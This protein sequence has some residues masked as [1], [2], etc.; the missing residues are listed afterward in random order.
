[1]K[2]NYEI[3]FDCPK[4]FKEGACDSV[5]RLLDQNKQDGFFSI[6]DLGLRTLQE[7]SI[8]HTIK[9]EV[10]PHKSKRIIFEKDKNKL[11]KKLNEI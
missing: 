9:L 11:R 1:M 3:R 4:Q 2:N 8:T 5:K 10:I 7:K 6:F